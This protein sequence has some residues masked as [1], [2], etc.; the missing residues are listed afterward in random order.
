VFKARESINFAITGNSQ[1]L[2]AARNMIPFLNA[3]IVGLDTLY[4]AATGYGLNPEEKAKAQRT[5]AT[6]ASMMIAMSLAY[7]AMMQDDDDYKKLPDYVKDGN[8]LFPLS[9]KDGKTFVR[10][11]VPYEVG[12]LF[13][14][15]PEVLVRYMS[16]TSTGKE[17]LASLKAGFIQNMPTGGVPIPQFAKPTLEVISNHSFH[18]GRDIEGVGDS[19][20]PVSD[21]G[22]KASEFS[23][24]MSK[25]GLDNIGMSPAKIDVFL[26]GTFAEMGTFGL[27][28]ADSLIL[29]ASGKEKTPKNFENMPFM[30]SFLTDPQVNK[31]IS[32]FYDLEKN[33]TQ[34]ANLFTQ[35]KNE[36]RGEELQALVSDKE[37]LAQIGAAPTLRK[38]SQEMTKINQAINIIDKSKD[39]PPQERRD[40]IN[41]LQRVLATVAQQGYQVAGIAGLPR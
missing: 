9:D 20:L 25:A 2:A 17:A 10:V 19:R 7:A 37:K 13:K 26:K 6:R 11:V 30:R 23:K 41:E 29:A 15:I 3:T 16:G 32:D 34:V 38:L 5:F 22:R 12:Y 40:R 31:A 36:G 39:I 24:M 27:E 18:T 14:T 35:Y 8:W 28:L 4:R 21:R 33:A 1:F